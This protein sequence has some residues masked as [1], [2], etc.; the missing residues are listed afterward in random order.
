V[1]PAKATSER[2]KNKNMRLLCRKPLVQW[3][4]EAALKSEVFTDV[5]VS[6]ED[7]ATLA[8]AQKLG[9]RPFKRSPELASHTATTWQVCKEVLEFI[10]ADS[11]ALLLP[12]SPFRTSQD[13]ENACGVFESPDVSCLLSVSEFDYPPQW[14]LVVEG[15]RVRPV[16]FATIGKIRQE[17]AKWYKHDGSII[18]AKTEAF[19]KA[20]DW[21]EMQPIPWFTP[22]GQNID[23]D[24]LEDFKRAE[25]LCFEDGGGI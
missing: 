7:E 6:S 19:L 1:I 11:F 24:T 22:E 12:T 21:V 13:I 23:L 2:I 15:D 14:A 25:Y 16:N 18:M 8:L 10:K 5:I 3:T 9:A 20:G 17:L 4:I